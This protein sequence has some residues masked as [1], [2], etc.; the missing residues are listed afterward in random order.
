MAR[1]KARPDTR[2]SRSA[3]I[4]A[5]TVPSTV[6]GSALL[7]LALRAQDLDLHGRCAAGCA[8]TEGHHLDLV[9]HGLHSRSLRGERR[10]RGAF[11]SIR[12]PQERDHAVADGG[13]DGTAFQDREPLLDVSLNLGVG[14]AARPAAECWPSPPSPWSE[15]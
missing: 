14:R 13:A 8:R 10:R 4:H 6:A 11:A 1:L 5:G 3:F 7:L 9:V 2:R 12:A 15:G